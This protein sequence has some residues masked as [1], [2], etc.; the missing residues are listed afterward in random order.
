MIA[1]RSIPTSGFRVTTAALLILGSATLHVAVAPPHLRE[2]LPFGITFLAVGAAQI[3]LAIEFLARP[4]RRFS[5]LL[6]AMNAGFIGAWFI[7]RTSGLP[8]GPQ[9]G[10]PEAVGL[11]DVV[12]VVLE[13]LAA[14][15]LLSLMARPSRIKHNRLWRVALG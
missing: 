9:P 7:S 10:V 15:F 11:T 14:V 1:T 8:V 12:C 6:L 4:S 5:A 13:I 3:I 2:Y